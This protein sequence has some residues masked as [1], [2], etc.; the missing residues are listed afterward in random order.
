MEVF[1]ST[2]APVPSSRETKGPGRCPSPRTAHYVPPRRIQSH[3]LLWNCNPHSDVVGF[4]VSS[5]CAPGASAGVF[6]VL[7]FFTLLH[8]VVH[9]VS[10]VLNMRPPGWALSLQAM[11][12]R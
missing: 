4:Q 7:R 6:V 3:R 10:S 12:R 2:L 11:P 5:A 8:H 9:F 1:D